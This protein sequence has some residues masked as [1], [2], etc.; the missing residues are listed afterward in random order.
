M[1]W[2]L[3]R[4]KNSVPQAIPSWSCFVSQSGSVPKQLTTIAYYPVIPKP[5]TEYKTVAECLRYAEAA[6]N[7]VGQKY[8]ITTFDL[9]ACMKAYPLVFN[10][11]L[12]YKDHIVLIGSFH[13]TMA[14]LKMI[15]K[16]M[17]GS[18]LEDI[19][20]EADLIT[21]GS[22]KG[23]MSGKHFERSMH[24]HKVMFECLERLLLEQFMIGR[25][26]L[27]WY[28]TLPEESL[29]KLYKLLKCSTPEILETLLTDT[30]LSKFMDSFLKFQDE[31]RVGKHGKTAKLWMSYM[32]HTS[33]ILTLQEAVQDNN[34]LLFVYVL[35]LMAILFFAYNR[36]NYARHL[37]FIAMFLANIETSHPGA[38]Q[39][40]KLGAFSV[41]RSFCPGN[42]AAV[43]KTMEETFMRHAKSDRMGS[44]ITGICMNYGNYQRWIR[45]ANARS[46]YVNVTL[47]KAGMMDDD[48]SSKT[49]KDTKKTSKL[50]LLELKML[51][52]ALSTL[53]MQK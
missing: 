14:Y 39:L 40:L 49:H 28:S 50:M 53:L 43:D 8:V 47:K 51:F 38:S 42:R 19:L 24:C 6:T 4:K 23:V 15:G 33:L 7:E 41:A 48:A 1:L 26:G 22:L 46:Q 21:S 29:Q 35:Y 5:I 31:I 32:D 37:T 3:A 13:A 52:A 25:E 18:G 11:P 10:D 2:V 12:K 16:K 27:E 44:G 9:G 45:S 30:S 17:S 20:I 34:Y 36:Q